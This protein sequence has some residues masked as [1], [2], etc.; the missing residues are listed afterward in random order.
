[1]STRPASSGRSS[2]SK[3]PTTSEG[4]GD[5]RML[6]RSQPSSSGNLREF[7]TNHLSL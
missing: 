7:D 5:G 4:W 2:F 3:G 1:V 6:L